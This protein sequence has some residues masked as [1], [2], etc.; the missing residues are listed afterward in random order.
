METLLGIIQQDVLLWEYIN[1]ACPVNAERM[2][3]LSEIILGIGHKKKEEQAHQIY[4][5]GSMLKEQDLLA[6]QMFLWLLATLE[7]NM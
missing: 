1:Q 7:E 6:R 2:Q 3:L 5:Y 4:R